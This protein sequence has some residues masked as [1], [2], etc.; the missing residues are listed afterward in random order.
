MCSGITQS[1]AIILI[2]SIDAAVDDESDGDNV[3]KTIMY[4]YRQIFFAAIRSIFGSA[5]IHAC[6]EKK[7]GKTKNE[8]DTTE[9]RV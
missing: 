8:K 7:K 1:T 3:I 9:F 5:Q 4:I 6:N 2:H